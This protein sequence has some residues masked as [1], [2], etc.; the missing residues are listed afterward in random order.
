M[1]EKRTNKISYRIANAIASTL[2]VCIVVSL[3][4]V[5]LKFIMWLF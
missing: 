3:F 2:G 4:A 5:T 1:E